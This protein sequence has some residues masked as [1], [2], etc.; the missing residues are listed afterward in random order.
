MKKFTTI[1]R[2]LW[3]PV[4]VILVLVG[5]SVFEQ[6]KFPDEGPWIKVRKGAVVVSYMAEDT[7]VMKLAAN[8]SVQFLGFDNHSIIGSCLVRTSAGV[9][10]WTP[11]W[12]LDTPL[13]YASKPYVGDTVYIDAPGKVLTY[14]HW[15]TP[16]PDSPVKGTLSDGTVIERMQG[17]YVY[18]AIKDF[19]DYQIHTRHRFAGVTSK[20]KFD[21]K[22]KG[23]RL[24]EMKKLGPVI[25]TA[26]NKNGELSARF[27]IYAFDSD[28]GC[29]YFPVIT[30]GADS[31]AVSTDFVE[32][33]DRS[34]WVLRHLPF[35]SQI[36]DFP[37]TSFFARSPAYEP[38]SNGDILRSTP[39]K[40]L[41]WI[42]RIIAIAG[43]L[44]WLFGIGLIP[45]A[46]LDWVLVNRP[47]WLRALPDSVVKLI[48]IVLL[49][50]VYYYWMIVLLA[51]GAYWWIGILLY[52]AAWV[53]YEVYTSPL[54]DY[55]PHG[56]CPECRHIHSIVLMKS[57]FVGSETRMENT[58]ETQKT[59]EDKKKWETW[60][61]VTQGNQTW[62]ENIRLHTETTSHFRN[63]HYRDKVKYDSYKL[64]YECMCCGYKEQA[65]KTK[66]KRLERIFKGSDRHSTTERKDW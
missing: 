48:Y 54:E 57:D 41:F 13:I 27:F 53:I 20:S 16:A 10:G 11:M 8:D 9:M 29:F 18:P 1:L 21:E 60:T 61:Q 40:I 34:D 49:G 19:T 39:K 17:K 66:R 51:W 14:R 58:T 15:P 25:N 26:Y 33:T 28:D 31:V 55:V 2:Q 4:T 36:Y 64:H 6:T 62:R 37:L 30:F 65:N 56:R 43:A 47:A 38:F 32:A 59:G 50:V 3:V 12:M 22:A 44:V 45:A 35:A 46:L 7:V 23:L 24:S 5:A 42:V 52:G 63:D